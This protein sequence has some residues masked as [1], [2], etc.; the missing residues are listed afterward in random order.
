MIYARKAVTVIAED[1]QFTII[2]DGEP[3]SV[4]PP[5]HHQG[6]PPLQALRGGRQ[7]RAYKGSTEADP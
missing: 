1:D 7:P 5:H 4:V 2:I 6:S 3:A